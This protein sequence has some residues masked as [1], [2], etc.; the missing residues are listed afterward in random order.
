MSTVISAGIND[1]IDVAD[2]TTK[3]ALEAVVSLENAAVVAGVGAI[4]V[5]DKTFDAT[6][7]EVEKARAAFIAAIRSIAA[8]VVAPVE[9]TLNKVT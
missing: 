5:G 9:E 2:V 1:I 4:T 6:A 8:A 7:I 3:K